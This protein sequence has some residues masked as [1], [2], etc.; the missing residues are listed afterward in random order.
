MMGVLIR[1]RLEPREFGLLLAVWIGLDCVG[2]WALS[3]FKPWTVMLVVAV[4]GFIAFG[5][6]EL[7]YRYWWETKE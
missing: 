6:V 7:V 5:V 2:F 3:S 4:A 1:R